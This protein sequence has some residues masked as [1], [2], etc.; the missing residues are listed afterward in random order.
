MPS[1]AIAIGSFLMLLLCEIIYIAFAKR[2]N[3]GIRPGSHKPISGGGIVFIVAAWISYIITLPHST[4]EVICILICASILA[5]ISFIDDIFSISPWGRLIVHIATVA[6]PLLLIASDTDIH[7]LCIFMILIAGTATINMYNFMDG[8]NGMTAAYSVVTLLSIGFFSLHCQQMPQVLTALLLIATIVFSIF[9][10]R[11]HELCH[12]GDVGSIVMGFFILYLIASLIRNTTDFSYVSLLWVYIIDSGYTV[13]ARALKGENIIRGHR[14]HLY[15]I[16]TDKYRVPHL[17]TATTY[18]IIQLAINAGLAVI[19]QHM[20]IGYA[21]ST[22]TVLLIV[23]AT[24]K[25][26]CIHTI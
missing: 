15:Q 19:P 6:A 1:T 12:C 18:A 13:I 17:Y 9:N 16:I 8:I 2:H 26:K 20:H 4:S 5:I 24:L 3:I 25:Y 23:Y 7:I 11:K 22:F 21:I 14:Q 10:F